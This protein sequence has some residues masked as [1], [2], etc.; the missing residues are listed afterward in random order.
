MKISNKFNKLNKHKRKKLM[1]FLSHDLIIGKWF[2]EINNY[3]RNIQKALWICSL[4]GCAWQHW[5]ISNLLAN[6]EVAISM[7][8]DPSVENNHTHIQSTITDSYINKKGQ[9]LNWSLP[10]FFII[11]SFKKIVFPF[12]GLFFTLCPPYIETQPYIYLLKHMVHFASQAYK[13]YACFYDYCHAAVWGDQ[14]MSTTGH[15]HTHT[16]TLKGN[17]QGL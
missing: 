17:S 2:T 14:P 13:V 16:Y 8:F 7:T 10:I 15:T 5:F 3:Y 11:H 9:W 1:L 6:R 12:Q 4:V